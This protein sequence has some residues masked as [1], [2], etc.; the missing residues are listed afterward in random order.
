E[1][2]RLRARVD[3]VDDGGD[4]PIPAR[5]RGAHRLP[6]DRARVVP[7]RQGGVRPDPAG[8]GRG[9]ERRHHRRAPLRHRVRGLPVPAV[10]GEGRGQGA[11]D[12]RGLPPEQLQLRRAISADLGAA[13]SS[14]SN[15]WIPV[16]LLSLSKLRDGGVFS[17]ILPTEFLTGISANAVRNWLLANAT[18]LTIDLFKPGSFPAVLQRSEER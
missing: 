2:A 18:D 13:G 15:L 6:G 10:R 1:R 3:V 12:D 7:A 9:R 5:L 16:F 11:V 4:E 8:P 14:V 17:M